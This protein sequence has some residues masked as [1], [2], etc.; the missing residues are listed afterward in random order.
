M[1]EGCFHFSNVVAL[2]VGHERM[3]GRPG[4]ISARSESSRSDT[5]GKNLE[6]PSM[7]VLM[8]FHWLAPP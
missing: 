6:V 2:M 5:R 3:G 1:A 4:P 8:V 7:E